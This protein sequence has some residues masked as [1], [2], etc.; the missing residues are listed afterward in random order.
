[1]L[2]AIQNR[3]ANVVELLLDLRKKRKIE[4]ED[5]ENEDN[6]RNNALH[7]AA[8]NGSHQPWGMPQTMKLQWEIKW[9]NDQGQGSALKLHEC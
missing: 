8:T 5:V 3:Q 1:M 6:K 7:L 2:L 4:W 9:S